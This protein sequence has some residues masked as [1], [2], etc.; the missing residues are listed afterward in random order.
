MGRK[1]LAITL[2]LSLLAGAACGWSQSG[3]RADAPAIQPD[4][5]VAG[6]TASK[7]AAPAAARQAAPAP[8]A[9]AA[10]TSADASQVK[11]LPSLDRMLIRTVTMT[12]S[13]LNVQEAHRQAERIAVEHGGLIAGSQVRQEG[14]RMTATVTVRIPA[15]PTTYQATMERLRGIAE[16]VVD[17]QSQI[18]D[19]TE[20]HVDLESRLRN[21]QATE[22]S[23]RALLARA[24]RIEDILPIQ[25]E[26]TNVRG[27]IEQVQ[28]RKQALERRSEMATITLQLREHTAVA[29]Q[30]WDLGGTAGEA[31]RALARAT[32]GM[33]TAMVWLVVWAPLWAGAALAVW[34]VVRFRRL[35]FARSTART[36]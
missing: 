9:Q 13:V 24:Q 36:A 27:Q 6:E 15:D 16:K 8:A 25:R 10:A 21:L 14:E 29:R 19:I 5:G 23:L 17:E 34:L 1:L 30:D 4:A 33:V 35:P 31:L 20:E 2:A 7:P 28:G 18:Q 26:L 3:P 22:D 32:R 12:L 11:N